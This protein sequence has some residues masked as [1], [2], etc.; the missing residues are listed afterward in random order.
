M[1]N[2]SNKIG[3]SGG[4]TNTKH[5]VG[6]VVIVIIIFL[7]YV[8]IR[9]YKR[10]YIQSPYLINGLR[11]GTLSKRIPAVMIPDSKDGRYGTEF[12]YSFWINISDEN[13]IINNEIAPANKHIFHKGSDDYFF[14]STSSSNK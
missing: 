4:Y 12:T 3:N 1:N 10:S 7:L 14:S 6:V 9:N 8:F 13:F 2:I 5:L 11:S